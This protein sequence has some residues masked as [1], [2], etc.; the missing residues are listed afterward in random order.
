MNLYRF[1]L[2][3][4]SPWRTPWQADTL[5]GLLC[6]TCARTEGDDVLRQQLIEPALAGRPPFVLSDAFPGDRLPLPAAVRALDVPAELRKPLK[7]ARWLLSESFRQL[8]AGAVPGTGE[9]LRDAGVLDYTQL[10]NTIGRA[11]NTTN[12]GGGLFPTEESV[13]KKGMRH[14]TVYARIVPEFRENFERLVRELTQWGFGSDRSAGKGQFRLDGDIEPIPDL[15]EVADADGCVSL[16]TFQ[17]AGDDP[18]DG[19]W[20]AFT[21]YGKLGPDFGLENVFKKPLILLRPG[22]S[23]RVPAPRGWLGRAIPMHDLL[24]HDVVCH[25]QG[26]G[27]N[28]IHW[29]FGLCLPV[30]WPRGEVRPSD[31]VSELAIPDDPP[32]VPLALAEPAPTLVLTEPAPL[33]TLGPAAQVPEIVQPARLAPEQVFVKVLERREIGGKV[34]YLVQEKGKPRGVLAYG[35]PPPPDKLPQDGD[36][37]AVY[38]NNQDPRNPQYRWDRPQASQSKH[39]LGGRRPRHRM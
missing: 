39:G 25:L 17:P 6:W 21:K 20:E 32:P 29:A 35:I 2:I 5:G 31:P 16:S 37:I 12:D 1:R 7:R 22:A 3:P 19:A 18:T 15:D 8:Q 4:E 23:F 38:R 34:Q 33:Q 9:M 27:A 24:A 26:I 13:L 30:H 36:E 11:S 28:V 14:L 10:R